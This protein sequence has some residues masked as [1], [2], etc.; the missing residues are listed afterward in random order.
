MKDIIGE[1]LDN[2]KENFKRWEQE[3]SDPEFANSTEFNNA[4]D[5]CTSLDQIIE[6][7]SYGREWIDTYYMLDLCKFL[8]RLLMEQI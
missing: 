2:I 4:I 7:Y 6:Y 3:I 8:G 1:K 5:K